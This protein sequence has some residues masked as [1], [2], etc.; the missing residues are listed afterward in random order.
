[1]KPR[2]LTFDC[3]G[4]LIDWKSGIGDALL[5]TIKGMPLRG[6]KLHEAYLE[7]EREEEGSYKTYRE[8]LESSAVRLANASGVRITERDARKFADSVPYWPAF[9]DTSKALRE[10]G[11]RGYRRFILSNVDTDLL[12][13]TIRKNG[14]EVDGYVTAQQTKTYKPNFGHWE[15]FMERAGARKREILHVAQSL[16]HDIAPT[17]VMGIESAWVNRYREA[18][19]PHAEPSYIVDNLSH[20]TKLLD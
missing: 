3:Y 15:R 13:E 10:L 5:E 7:A 16:Y 12:E 9:P 6:N 17:Q 4:T 18:L 14:L 11:E 20:L 1:M 2:F 19:P 8:V